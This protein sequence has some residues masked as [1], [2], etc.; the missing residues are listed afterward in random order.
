MNNPLSN[1]LLK[2]AIL[3]I[4]SPGGSA[5]QDEDGN[6][7]TDGDTVTDY[8]VYFKKPGR[9]PEVNHEAGQ[10]SYSVYLKGYLV[11]PKFLP[12]N[13]RLPLKVDGI[14][15]IG[16]REQNFTFELRPSIVPVELAEEILGQA[17]EGWLY[18]S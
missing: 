6:W 17:I 3:K 14:R 18:Y 15:T 2:K 1:P 5:I 10:D 11:E 12:A 7:K 9:Q 13:V 8:Q 4:P 16:N